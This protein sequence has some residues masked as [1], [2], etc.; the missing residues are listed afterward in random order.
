[1]TKAKSGKRTVRA[2]AKATRD[3]MQKMGGRTVPLSGS[4]LEKGDGRLAGRFRIETKRPPTEKYRLTGADWAKI[5]DAAL[6]SNEIPVFHMKLGPHSLVVLREEDY[7]GLGGTVHGPK[8]VGEL[9]IQ[10]GHTFDVHTWNGLRLVWKHARCMVDAPLP[11]GL[12][13]YTLRVM[14]ESDFLALVEA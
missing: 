5:R 9:G 12:M 1:M 10:M 3:L 11:G 13:T 7:I 6:R 2:S 4:G 8:H 14:P